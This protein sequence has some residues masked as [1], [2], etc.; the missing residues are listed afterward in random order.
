MSPRGRRPEWLDYEVLANAIPGGV[1]AFDTGGRTIYA[2]K[3]AATLL[4]QEEEALLGLTLEELTT[5]DWAEV[6]RRQIKVANE[7]AQSTFEF[8]FLRKEARETW[9]R[10]TLSPATHKGENIGA[11]AILSDISSERKVEGKL[12]ET[13]VL[14]RDA[15]EHMPGIIFE[16]RYSSENG[17]CVEYVSGAVKT[18][19]GVSAEELISRRADVFAYIHP[20]DVERVKTEVLVASE[21]LEPAS[22]QFRIVGEN[23]VFHVYSSATIVKSEEGTTVITGVAINIDNLKQVETKLRASEAQLNAVFENF[24]FECWTLDLESRFLLQ[25]PSSQRRWGDLRGKDMSCVSLPGYLHNDCEEDIQKALCG[26]VARR[27]LVVLVNGKSNHF[28]RLIVPILSGDEIFGVLGVTVDTTEERILEKQLAQSKKLDAIGRLAGGVAHDFN[29]I[30]TAIMSCVRLL[31]RRLEGPPRR[32]LQIIR[33]GAQRAAQLTRQL[34]AFA[35]QEKVDPTINSVDDVIS[36]SDR[37]LRRLIGEDIELVT[38][39]NA[40]GWKVL[41][42]PVRLEQA[43]INLVVN[44]KNAMEEGGT[45]LVRS[46]AIELKESLESVGSRMPPGQY[47]FIGVSDSGIGMSDDT[48][49]RAFEPFFTTRQ[50]AGGTGLGLSSVYGSVHQAGGYVTL[51]TEVNRGTHIGLYLPRV[52]TSSL[53]DGREEEGLPVQSLEDE[54]KTIVLVEDDSLV[55]AAACNALRLV[56]YS[57]IPTNN[58]REALEVAKDRSLAIDVLLTD[59]EL[60]LESGVLGAGRFKELRPETQVIY[61]SGYPKNRFA[62]K[63]DAFFLAK[64]FTPEELESQI[65]QALLRSTKK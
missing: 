47:A 59:I 24:P 48:K 49:A 46:D 40:Q 14:L 51:E 21:S 41:V 15:T 50:E 7:G 16:L 1:L 64:P 29:N 39:R 6:A 26:E 55:M 65:R 20:E 62:L 10:V 35:K 36:K 32:E 12:R 3:R 25:N 63:S 31:E 52:C 37:L 57:V 44:A 11:I 61:M 23:Q 8:C 22:L 27:E 56:G 34:L 18:F 33:D 45:I 17:L 53:N 30:I 5:S 38:Q 19:V 60:P 42:D 28:E 2:S 4:G 54:P 43:I 58:S 9:A 13:E